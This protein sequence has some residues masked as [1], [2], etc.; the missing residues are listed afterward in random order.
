MIKKSKQ[1]IAITLLVFSVGFNLWLYRNEPTAVIDPNDNAF[2]YGLIDRTNQIWDYASRVCPKA[3]TYPFCHLSLLT[4]HW[5]PNWAEGYNLPYYYSHIPQILIVG[6]YR[7]FHLPIPLFQYYHVIIYV[8]LCLFPLS[9][10]LAFRIMSFPWLTAGLAALLASLISTDGLYGIDQASF[11]WRGWGLSSQLFALFWFPLVVA[12]AVRYSQAADRLRFVLPVILFLVLATAGHLGIGMMAFMAVAV[13]L[14]SPALVSLLRQQAQKQV[15]QELV[16]G[17]KKTLY[18]TVPALFVLSYWIVPAF[19]ENNFHNTSLWDPVWKFNSFGAVEVI[20]KLVSGDLFDFG[21]LPIYTFLVIIGCFAALL[22][23]QDDRDHAP[24][25]FLFFFFLV[26]FFGRTTWG[27]LIDLVPGMSEFHGHRFIVG[28]H[29]AGLFLAPIGCMWLITGISRIICRIFHIHNHTLVDMMGYC[30]VV[31]FIFL[32]LVPQIISY[33]KYNDTLIAEANEQYKVAKPDSDVLI[34]TLQALQKEK[35]GRVY[36]LRGNEGKNFRIAS[37]PYYMYLSTYG[38]PTVLWLPETWSPNSDTEQFFSED[39]PS[40]YAL[41]N[42]R[43]VV[44]PK[45]GKTPQPFWKPLQQTN[46]WMLYEVQTDGYIAAGTAPSVVYSSKNAFIN[47]VHLWIQ[48]AYPDRQ[49]FPELQ[50]TKPAA[51]GSHINLPWFWMLDAVT[52]RTPDAKQHSLAAEPPVYVNPAD[53]L[54]MRIT[55]QTD[56]AD[57]RFSATVEVTAPCPACIV[58]LRETF[59]PSW[60][61][62]VNGK[63]VTPI[64]VFPF[65]TAIRLETPGAYTIMYSYAP[66]AAKMLLFVFGVLCSISALLHGVYRKR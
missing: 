62:T 19:L 23:T 3:I 10:F 50:L 22:K 30:F 20:T 49:V 54:P 63:R 66:T 48:S 16:T 57:M 25:S 9:L 27:G 55:E 34:S 6:S 41:Y 47:L 45:D 46:S 58:V 32:T 35:P 26:L 7:L 51:Q 21:R 14:L 31:I 39:N 61:A 40:H 12:S 13:I 24:F 8:L 1:G 42:I 65:F 44:T 4:D 5:V 59:H 29:L 52:Y 11:L 36:A 43:Y 60:T 28:L 18:S 37:T 64:I 38:I 33:A 2:Q 56:D 53:E 17:L 15:L